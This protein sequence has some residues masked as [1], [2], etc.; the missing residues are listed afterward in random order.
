MT[1]RVLL[2]DD[3]Q[4]VRAGLAQLLERGG[5]IEV[6]GEAADG[7]EAQAMAMDLSP[8]VV[9]MDIRMPGMDG[10]EATRRLLAQHGERIRI[11]VLTTFELDEYVFEALRLGAT[12]FLL[13]DADPDELRRAVRSAAEGNAQLSPS[14]T[15]R[16]VSEF[17]GRLARPP[18]DASPLGVL[19]DREREVVAL[20]GRGLTN[21]EIADH[22]FMSP[23][24]AKTHVSRAITKLNS[25]DRA[26]LVVLAYQT[27][28]VTPGQE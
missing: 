8:D 20:V 5:E 26:G 12:G 7:F 4:L 22:L 17:A 23:A 14:V 1:V 24:T 21:A 11:V 15:K 19:T 13:K 10:L 18:L 6:V 16:M 25:R 3:Q 27:G 2:V 9:V 28:L